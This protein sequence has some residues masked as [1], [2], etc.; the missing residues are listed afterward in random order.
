[1]RNTSVGSTLEEGCVEEHRGEP[2]EKREEGEGKSMST[3]RY[4]EV[5]IFFCGEKLGKFIIIFGFV[6]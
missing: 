5:N 3:S 1:M 4:Y 6:F 2:D